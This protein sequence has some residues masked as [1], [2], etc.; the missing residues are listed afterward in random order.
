VSSDGIAPFSLQ[1]L[2]ELHFGPG[3]V[4]LLPDLCSSRGRRL[5][6]VTGG[7]TLHRSP[8]LHAQVAKL[9]AGGFPL[10]RI[11]VD[12]EPSPGLIDRVASE[13]RDKSI[14]VVAAVGG[15]SV[16]DAGKAI[17]AMLPQ[18]L[19][20]ER[21]IEGREG[22]LAHDGRKVPFIA[23][24]TTS[25][26]GSEVTSNAVI[27]RVGPD[28]FKRSLR[29]PAFVPDAAIL[30]PD[31]MVTAPAG[32][33]ASSGM[34]ACTQL[35]EAYVSPFASP[36]TDALAVSGLERFG[37]SFEAACTTG[38]GDV[39]VR[40]DIAYAAL[41]SG[42]ALANAGLGIVHGFASSIGGLYEIPHGVLCATLLAE[43]T[44]VN[45]RKLQQLDPRHPSLEKFA[46]AG[47][48]LSGSTYSG[49]PEGCDALYRRLL[50]WEEQLDFPGLGTYGVRADDLDGIVAATRSKS[51]AV[52]LDADDMREILLARL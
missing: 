7:A 52:R 39:A 48:M 31:L 45:I 30:D 28:G 6:L 50:S 20:V 29:H 10:Y 51:N 40:G 37:R 24:P 35:L 12:R 38:A 34:D 21:F 46:R 14:D 44:R 33:T 18:C 13:F 19:P 1:P 17:S 25:G 23:V 36:F 32:L 11:V 16:L 2:P 3:R 4:E 41:M 5:L 9:V 26:T 43:A 8:V 49:I 47:S 15:G 22:F 27:S 42:I